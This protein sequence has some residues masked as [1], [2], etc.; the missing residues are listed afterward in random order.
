MK[1]LAQRLAALDPEAS[2]ALRVIAHFDRLSTAHA[3]LPTIVGEAA[4]LARCPVRL[5]DEDHHLSVRVEA[6]GT[7]RPAATAPDADWARTAIPGAGTAR[8]WLER[9]A[10]AG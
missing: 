7:A 1:D 9:P 4:A 8:M 5:V 2:A 10:P 6:D 3:S